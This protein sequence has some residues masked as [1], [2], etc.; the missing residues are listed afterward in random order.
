MDVVWLPRA[1]PLLHVCLVTMGV[2][3]AVARFL[4]VSVLMSE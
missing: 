3:G 2:G 1:G 4:F